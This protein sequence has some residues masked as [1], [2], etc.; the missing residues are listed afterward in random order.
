M[1][2]YIALLLVFSIQLVNS[3]NCNSTFSGEI[4][5][6]HDGTSLI[7]AAIYL[8]EIDRYVSSDLNGKFKFQN[9]CNG[10]IT[11]VISHIGCETKETKLIVTG[12]TAAIIRLEHHSEELDVVTVNGSAVH[13]QTLT[14]QETILKNELLEKYSAA[15]LGEALKEVSGVSAISTGNA[16]VKPVING[17]HSSRVLI[18]NNGVR[19]QDQDWGIEHAPNIDVNSAESIT[20][21]KGAGALAYGGD[22]I[23]GV[24][25]LNPIRIIKKD[26]LYGKSIL[27]AQSNGRGGSLST[28][29]TKTYKN[30][31]F[32]SGQGTYKHLGD[33][34]APNYILTNTGVKTKAISLF[35]GY[36]K[37]E[38]GFDVYY[39][40]INNN[41][42]ILSASHI[43]N[44][45]DLV[46]A[47]NNQ[48]PLIEENFSYDLNNPKQEITHH[49]LKSKF[50]KRFENF[51]KLSAQYD[52]Q[53]NQ[54]FEFDKRIGA[55]REKPSVDLVLKTHT[56]S[57]N[58]KKDS[59][60]DQVFHVGSIAR[61]Q[62][63][64][65]NPDTGVRRLIPDY[66]KIDVGVFGTAL[67]KLNSKLSFDAALRYDF[68]RIDAKKFYQ[69]SRWIERNYDVDFSEIIIE[70]FG[71]QLLVNPKFNYHNISLSTGIQYKFNNELK[72]S[73]NYTMSN[74]PPNPSELFSDGLHHS[75]ARIELGDL[76]I[77]EEESHN[78]STELAYDGNK[79][80]GNVN[81]YYN[82]IKDF[83]YI[84]PFG[85]E[86][87][88]RGA[89]PV[90]NYKQ[91]DARLIG[92]N[93]NLAYKVHK[94]WTISNKSS[95][96]KGD[97]IE[98]NKPLID[99]PAFNTV[100][101]LSFNKPNWLNL[102]TSLKSELIA[103]QTRYPDNNFEVF[104]ATSNSFELVDISSTPNGYHLLHFTSSVSI[105]KN[106]KMPLELGF[107]V[108]NLMNT[109]YRDYLS[110]LRYFSDD[111]GRNMMLSVKI[112]Y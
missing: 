105:N 90:W 23:G 68:N 37:F 45:Q 77:S 9:L 52:F 79:F 33:F 86:Q 99:I 75:A 73:F 76:R 111:I 29:L 58:L 56:L 46:N 59:N 74:R 22:A 88:I 57:L 20:V 16:I 8:K 103:K 26:S 95:F 39:S 18:I 70:D 87:T 28:S 50:Y 63:N 4:K 21:I 109:S 60:K 35:S 48:N 112:N 71:T 13:R 32:F 107:R 108:N 15:T 97:N 80:S 36:K 104:I 106:T 6:F 64:F 49:L 27:N 30:G 43:G 40:Y 96:I 5:D 101:D 83:I 62:S 84:A 81:F 93:I 11:L 85:T 12:D 17:L 31:F 2:Y 47:I 54:R 61:Y 92:L 53:H 110:R 69:K 1:K 34:E 41:L 19:L 51:G 98:D 3:Q 91:N 14:S 66:E 65:A 42:G 72:Y 38:K 78:F 10:T 100:T 44:I 7:G 94:N 55:D 102:K 89:F 67:F 24:V 25:V 82:H